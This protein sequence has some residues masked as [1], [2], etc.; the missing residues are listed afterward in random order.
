VE[1]RKVCVE[2]RILEKEQEEPSLGLRA[3]ETDTQ[4]MGLGFRT[5]E[6]ITG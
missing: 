5:L 6:I 2:E 1:A 4:G 3:L